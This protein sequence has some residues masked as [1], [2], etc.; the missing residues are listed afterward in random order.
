MPEHFRT[1]YTFQSP[2][3]LPSQPPSATVRVRGI[4]PLVWC[5][6]SLW[7]LDAAVG[8]AAPSTVLGQIFASNSILRG[9]VA[10]AA[11]SE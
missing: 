5:S 8:A 2:F 7:S 3:L 1:W 4:T 6:R 9:T 11:E 10:S